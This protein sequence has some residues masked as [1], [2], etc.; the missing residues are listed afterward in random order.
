MNLV[1]TCTIYNN[2]LKVYNLA[3]ATFLA[4]SL[5]TLICGHF[6]LVNINYSDWLQLNTRM[7]R[8][9]AKKTAEDESG[10]CTGLS[11]Y[12]LV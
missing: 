1:K 8:E 11:V 12:V 3:S 2:V 4:S 10:F 5:A 9:K 7:A 6:P